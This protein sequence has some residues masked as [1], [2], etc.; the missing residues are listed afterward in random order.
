MS[1]ND[2]LDC[3]EGSYQDYEFHTNGMCKNCSGR[4]ITFA[5]LPK[6]IVLY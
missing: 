4:E 2:C 3:D 1:G 6:L 5:T